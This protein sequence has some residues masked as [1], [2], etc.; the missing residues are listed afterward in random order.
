M[1]RNLSGLKRGGSPGRP[2][3]IGNKITEAMKEWA[4]DLFASEAWRTSAKKRIL[5]GRAPHLESHIIA[6]L[7]PKTEKVEHSGPDGGPIHTIENRYVTPPPPADARA[8]AH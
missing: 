6:T 2:K 1:A 8:A 5:A 4:S 7:L 3:G